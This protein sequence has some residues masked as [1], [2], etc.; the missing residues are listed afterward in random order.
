MNDLELDVRPILRHGGEP[1]GAIMGAVGRLAK[2]QRLKLYA[3]F[4]PE[5]LFHVM[6]SQGFASE[7]SALEDGEWMV[8]FT[9]TD[10]DHVDAVEPNVDAP[11]TWPDPAHYLD[12]TELDPPEPMVRILARLETMVDGEVLFALLGR[13]PIFLFP[14]L[15]ARGHA[16]VGDLD[17]DGQA[18]R[19]M[20]RAGGRS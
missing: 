17:E 14:E 9:P 15:Q 7:A 6:A 2:G 12:C 3:T 11:E 4:K 16:W 8:I 18:Y 10:R 5:P 20:I 19:L 1:F 13:E